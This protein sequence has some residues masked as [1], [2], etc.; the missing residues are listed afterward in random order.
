VFAYLV[1]RSATSIADNLGWTGGFVGFGLVAVG[2]SLPELVTA[3]AAARRGES[4]LIIGNLLGSNL[5]NSLTVG[6][7]VFLVNGPTPFNVAAGLPVWVLVVMVAVSWVVILLMRINRRIGRIEAVGLI[8]L[9]LT[10]LGWLAMTGAT[11]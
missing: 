4:G 11:A 9:Y 8:L 10:M 5:F 7:A 2:T 3:L 6:S 1:V